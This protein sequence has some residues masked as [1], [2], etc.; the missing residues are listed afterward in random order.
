MRTWPIP[1][2][3]LVALQRLKMHKYLLRSTRISINATTKP[4]PAAAG[5]EGGR[6]R[7]PIAP[8]RR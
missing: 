2:T 5:R 8:I 6:E 3:L 1:L 4:K 7:T